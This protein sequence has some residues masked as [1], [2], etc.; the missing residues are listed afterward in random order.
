MADQTPRREEAPL[1][2]PGCVLLALAIVLSCA[3]QTFGQQ[4]A[5]TLAGQRWSLRD[6]PMAEVA[7][8]VPGIV[9]ELRYATDRNLTGRAIYPRNAR[10]LL[11]Q[12][13]AERLGR[14]Q[15]ELSRQGFG[16]KVWDAYRPAWAHIRLWNAMPNPEYVAPPARGGSWHC[17][18]AAVDVTLVD[19]AG[20]EQAMPTD[21]DDFTP[22]AKSL[23]AGEDPVIAANVARLHAAM[24]HAGFKGARDEWWHFTAV[25]AEQFTLVDLPLERGGRY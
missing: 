10:C 12:S 16:L 19:L 1:K 17:Y 20:R 13:V 18:G 11:R 4:G 2:F 3:G 6:E 7:T 23:Y 25:N 21:F 9:V 5:V 15:E 8:V 14:A 22:A 24:E